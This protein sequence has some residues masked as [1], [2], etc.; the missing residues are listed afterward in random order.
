MK[1]ERPPSPN[2]RYASTVVTGCGWVTPFAAGTISDILTA[3]RTLTA[4]SFSRRSYRAVPD[5]FR[6]NVPGL[7]AELSRDKGA[8]ITAAA[9]TY[10]CRDASLATDS[11]QPDRVGVALGCSLAGQQ[12]MIDFAGEVRAQSSRFVSPIHFP[13]TVGNYVAGALARAYHLRGPNFTIASGVSA[14]LEAVLEGCSL[15]NNGKADVVFAGGA[16]RLSE[17][18]ARSFAP[19]R[20]DLSEGACLFVLESAAH[21]HARGGHVLASVMDSTHLR[22]NECPRRDRAA[23]TIVSVAG[24]TQPDAIVIEHWIGRCPGALAAAA[25]AA[26]IGA[27]NG[28]RVPC[29]S[30]TDPGLV[31]SRLIRPDDRR[32]SRDRVAAVVLAGAGRV[33]PTVLEL[34]VNCRA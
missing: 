9:L 3:E 11:L 31:S 28:L 1:R 34:I 33:Q 7:S 20:D 19:P 8:W 17:E 25:A 13:L 4:E 30:R 10:A 27:A 24:L 2:A 21:A 26:A 15:V 5:H 29:S 16:E 18:L 6:D 32:S 22:T 14:G 12:G 23:Q